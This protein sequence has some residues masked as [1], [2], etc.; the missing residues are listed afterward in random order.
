[1]SKMEQRQGARYDRLVADAGRTPAPFFKR[2]LQREQAPRWGRF[3][4]ARG[5][6]VPMA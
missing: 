6:S 5:G 3:F 1:M 4:D 2:W